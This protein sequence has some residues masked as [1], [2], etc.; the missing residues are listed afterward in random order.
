MCVI[1]GDFNARV[2]SRSDNDELT[3]VKEPH[4]Y[5]D[6]NEEL[7]SFLTINKAAVCN[8]WFQKRSIHKATWQHPGT[9]Q[10][11]C[12]DFAIVCQSQRKTCLDASVMHG[13][14]CN[15]HHQILRIK[16]N[17]SCERSLN[18][19][20]LNIGSVIF[21]KKPAKGRQSRKY[22]VSKLKGQATNDN[23]E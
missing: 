13:V 22:D 17:I 4:G 23:G 3:D 21:H 9:K 5:G 1:L 20:L 18:Q 14:E 15:M 12:I 6:A 11:H 16:L 8:T 2:G 7:L 19:Y 10:W